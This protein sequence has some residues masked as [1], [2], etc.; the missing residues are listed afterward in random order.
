MTLEIAQPRFHI[1]LR[2]W[3]PRVE[4]LA[5]TILGAKQSKLVENLTG[6]QLIEMS[7]AC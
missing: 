6:L 1:Y 7:L 5:G 4:G 2:T 3:S